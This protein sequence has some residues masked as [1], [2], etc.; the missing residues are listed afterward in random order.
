MKEDSFN[1]ECDINELMAS[2]RWFPPK[3]M[4]YF[5]DASESERQDNEF[6]MVEHECIDIDAR[7]VDHQ[8]HTYTPTKIPSYLSDYGL[9]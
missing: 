9:G 6:L 4:A 1:G 7:G 8:Q 5:V 2:R 3:E